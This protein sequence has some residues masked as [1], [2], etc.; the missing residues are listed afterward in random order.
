MYVNHS[1]AHRCYTYG[2]HGCNAHEHEDQASMTSVSSDMRP[3]S[4][5]SACLTPLHE[6]V[7]R[8]LSRC[9]ASCFLGT[10]LNHAVARWLARCSSGLAHRC[11][12][13]ARDVQSTRDDAAHVRAV[14]LSS[15]C[16]P[17]SF[18]RSCSV[19]GVHCVCRRAMVCMHVA[20][21]MVCMYGGGDTGC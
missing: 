3:V 21:R 15:L 13:I 6:V 19:I 14:F 11:V 16:A 18:I 9:L 20:M 5:M 10:G 2:S 1:D 7:P 17:S 4:L 12:L 8:V